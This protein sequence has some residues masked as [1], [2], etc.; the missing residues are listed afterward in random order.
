MALLDLQG[1]ELESSNNPTG[2]GGGGGG[3]G[4]SDLS[5]GCDGYSGL[6]VLLCDVD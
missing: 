1:L 5:I 2:G 6:S 4:D 3:G